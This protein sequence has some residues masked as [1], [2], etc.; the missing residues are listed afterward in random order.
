MS[1]FFPFCSAILCLV[2]GKVL[3]TVL[4]YFASKLLLGEKFQGEEND[5]LEYFNQLVRKYENGKLTIFLTRL[6]M[7][8]DELFPQTFVNYAAPICNV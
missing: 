2:A 6:Q 8:D 3:G 5:R 1:A 4:A 7:N